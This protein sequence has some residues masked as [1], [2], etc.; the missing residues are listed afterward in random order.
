MGSL[1][2]V[3]KLT[4]HNDAVAYD[5][6]AF[7]EQPNFGTHDQVDA[8]R[9]LPQAAL[10]V[11]WPFMRDSGGWGTQVIEP[12]A[13]LI[14]APRTRQSASSTNIRTRTASISSSVTPTCSAS[15][16]SPALTGWRAAAGCN[17]GLHTAWYLNGTM[18]DSMVGQSYRTFKDNLFPQNSGLH[19][20][21]SDVVA[22]TTF[23]PTQWLDLTY[24]TRLDQGTLA[25][26]MVDALRHGWQPRPS[27]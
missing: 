9:A 11:R 3:W 18:F 5:A 26:R 4:L 14:V 1:G 16:D 24:R 13:E 8:A 19:D 7:E 25:T 17:L 22:R 2:D 12:M 20:Q 6:S 10:D 15:I 23:A 27:R 21:V